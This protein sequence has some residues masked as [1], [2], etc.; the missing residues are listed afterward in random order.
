MPGF[1]KDLSLMKAL[2]LPPKPRLPLTFDSFFLT[3]A[4]RLGHAMRVSYW[5]GVWSVI[6]PGKQ[7]LN[8]LCP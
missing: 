1:P 5:M 3:W 8:M 4:R 6:P 7:S 2:H